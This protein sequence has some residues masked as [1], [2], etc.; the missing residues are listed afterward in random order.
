M[1]GMSKDLT[2]SCEDLA[3]NGTDY[4]PVWAGAHPMPEQLPVAEYK[5]VATVALLLSCYAENYFLNQ[6]F[7]KQVRTFIV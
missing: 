5:P 7:F 2:R 4:H 1:M 6:F 3:E